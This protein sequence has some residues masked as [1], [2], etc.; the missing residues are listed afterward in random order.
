[1]LCDRL[2]DAGVKTFID[3]DD[4]PLDGLSAGF[5]QDIVRV[6]PTDVEKARPIVEAFVA[7]AGEAE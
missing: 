4:S 1:M 6:L 2:E 3:N 5:G 7:E